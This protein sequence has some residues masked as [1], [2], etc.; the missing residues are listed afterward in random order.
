MLLKRNRCGLVEVV[1]TSGL[2]HRFPFHP[3]LQMSP[4]RRVVSSISF[5]APSISWQSVEIT[6]PPPAPVR[7][8]ETDM[9]AGGAE[10]LPVNNGQAMQLNAYSF[11][12]GSQ[13]CP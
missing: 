7:S 9:P 5:M 8:Y 3:L 10:A 2:I 13:I 1:R 4:L 12:I 6:M 11:M